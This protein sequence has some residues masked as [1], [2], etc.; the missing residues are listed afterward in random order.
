MC[1]SDLFPQVASSFE[2]ISKIEKAHGN[3]FAHFA[4]LMESGKLFVSD[5]KCGWLCLNCG[6]IQE[7][8]QAPKSC[9]VC[10]HDQGF[11]IRLEMA[12]YGGEILKA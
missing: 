4:E 12:P 6:H 2:Q 7:G 8:L 9:P 11:F 5:A 10:S 3:R 1:S